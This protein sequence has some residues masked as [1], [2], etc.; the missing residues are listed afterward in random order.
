MTLLYSNLQTDVVVTLKLERLGSLLF[1]C[2]SLN[3]VFT[4]TGPSSAGQS[5]VR[6]VHSSTIY[7]SL[8]F[9]HFHALSPRNPVRR[10][11]NVSTE[12]ELYPDFGTWTERDTEFEKLNDT[13]LERTKPALYNRIQFIGSSNAV[14][15]ERYRSTHTVD[16]EITIRVM[17]YILSRVPISDLFG[18]MRERL[19]LRA[20]WI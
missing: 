2:R 11:K 17:T 10:T 13:L 3:L 6:S 5:S 14:A 8:V 15:R 20:G 19:I 16:W 4:H 1:A 12:N 9:G 7:C 18:L